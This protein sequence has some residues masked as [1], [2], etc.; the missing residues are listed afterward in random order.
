M[1]NISI[2]VTEEFMYK[3]SRDAMSE[4]LE[5]W[6]D[7]RDEDVS[8]FPKNRL[9]EKILFCD[10]FKLYRYMPA[11]YFNIRNIETQKIHLSPN[12]TMNDIFEG[13]P[14]SLDDLSYSKLQ[15]IND[16]AYMT[17]MTESNDNILMWSHYAKNHEGVCVEFELKRLKEDT[18]HILEHLFPI[19]YREH[20]HTKRDI[21]SLAESHRELKKAIAGRYK[22]DGEEYLDDILPL[23]LIKSKDW[24]YE[25]E[26]R[27]LYTKKQM[28]DI[29]KEELYQGNLNFECLSAVYL[30]YRIH[31]EVKKNIIEICQRISTKEA[32]ISV[33]QAKLAPKS[34][35]IVFE[36][37]R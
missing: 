21:N 35:Q 22:Y 2:F 5:Y 12:G 30:G 11:E 9:S 15:E 17:C 27:I 28:Y 18:F 36:K 7:I 25:N 26:W 13:V 23:F 10:S 33:Y 3:E 1:I 14:E 6:E 34:Y 20:R 32:P 4:I 29:D 31:P 16:L 8:D 19:V 37:L 24:E